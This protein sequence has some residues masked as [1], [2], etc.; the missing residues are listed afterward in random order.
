MEVGNEVI[1][2]VAEVQEQTESVSTVNIDTVLQ[3]QVINIICLMLFLGCF[4]GSVFWY[5]SIKRL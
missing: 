3:L 2:T 5:H 1:S 4:L